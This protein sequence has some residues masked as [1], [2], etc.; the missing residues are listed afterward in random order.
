MSIVRMLGGGGP[1][2][3]GALLDR[4]APV[5]AVFFRRVVAR[6]PVVRAAVVPDDNVALAPGMA[7][8]GPGL[9]HALCQLLDHLVALALVEPLD[10]QDLAGIEVE[11]LPPGLG[12]SADDRMEDGCPVAVLLVEERRRVPAAAV[13]EGPAS[14]VETLLQRL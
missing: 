6:R 3:G 14:P 9:N 8:F 13:G 11:R 10:A 7:V 12:M 2:R 5:D 1:A 4:D